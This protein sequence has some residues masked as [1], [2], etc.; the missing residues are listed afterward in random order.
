MLPQSLRGRS[1][2]VLR[3]KG[4]GGPAPWR[5]WGNPGCPREASLRRG[6]AWRYT[7]P[8]RSTPSPQLR[9]RS[10]GAPGPRVALG[11]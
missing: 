2:P 8:R 1:S 9:A 6:G 11:N 7:T 4:T 3:G 5:C 10:S